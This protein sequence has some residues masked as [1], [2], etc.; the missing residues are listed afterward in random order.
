MLRKDREIFSRLNELL[1]KALSFYSYQVCELNLTSCRL[2]HV[3]VKQWKI[4]RLDNLPPMAIKRSKTCWVTG[5]IPL[6]KC[7]IST[8]KTVNKA[9]P[10]VSLIVENM[11][12]VEC[13]YRNNCSSYNTKL[14]FRST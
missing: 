14:S 7:P 8:C 3:K 13:G 5:K 4:D 1:D 12:I 11:F 10:R 9:S 6:I 2:L